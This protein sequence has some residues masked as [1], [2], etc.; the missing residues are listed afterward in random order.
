MREGILYSI[1]IPYFNSSRYIDELIE[2]I[3]ISPEFEIII[4][5]DKSTD[6]ETVYLKD[7]ISRYSSHNIDYFYNDQIKSAGTCRNIGI[8]HASGKWVI[9]ADADDYFTENFSPLLN[10]WKDADEDVIYFSPTSYNREEGRIGT[11]HIIYT[12]RIK[13]YIE[14]PRRRTELALK[15]DCVVPWSKIIKRDFIERHGFRFDQVI[16]SNDVMFSLRVAFSDVKIRCVDECMYCV[17]N[18]PR[19]LMYQCDRKSLDSRLNVYIEQYKFLKEKLTPVE[20]D[21]LHMYG[22][23]MLKRYYFAKQDVKCLFWVYWRLNKNGI[24]LFSFRLFNFKSVRKSVYM[25]LCNPF[26]KK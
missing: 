14:T 8:E 2:S 23:A 17:T 3:P 11:R 7:S 26:Y 5:D 1:I 18:N 24:K 9:F 22:T 15:S 10:K 25:I 13:D 19:S 4:V 20:F 16:A 6:D 21:S 12:S